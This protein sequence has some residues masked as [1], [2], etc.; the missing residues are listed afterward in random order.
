M[1]C[2]YIY[3]TL[4]IIKTALEAYVKVAKNLIKSVDALASA[5]MTT[6]RYTINSTMNVTI[7]LVKQYEKDLL[8]MLYNYL[9]GQ[10]RSLWCNKLWNCL[11]IANE[12]LDPE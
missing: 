10:D 6:V 4:S 2:T 9:F 7:N 8:D 11:A 5:L 3:G 1:L 12:L